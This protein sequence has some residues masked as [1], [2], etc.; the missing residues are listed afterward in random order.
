MR[1]FYFCF[2]I[3]YGQKRR[4][5]R[6][7]NERLK[8]PLLRLQPQLVVKFWSLPP[9]QIYPGSNRQ[10]RWLLSSTAKW[11]LLAGVLSSQEKWLSHLAI[12]LSQKIILLTLK[13]L[14]KLLIIG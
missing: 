6:H 14:P 8:K 11:L 9:H 7:Q 3:A 2:L 13:Q 10:L 5:S 4:V 1:T 12:F